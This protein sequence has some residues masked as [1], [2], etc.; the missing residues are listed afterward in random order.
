MLDITVD[1][2]V[3]QELKE[4]NEKTFESTTNAGLDLGDENC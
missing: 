2:Y 1:E 4:V 3:V